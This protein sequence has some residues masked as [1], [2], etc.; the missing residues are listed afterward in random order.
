MSLPRLVSSTSP[1]SVVDVE[2]PNLA[3]SRCGTAGNPSTV[4][5]KCAGEDWAAST[6]YPK[7]MTGY[8]GHQRNLEP[9][10][11]P[12]RVISSPLVG[13]TGNYRGKNIGKLGRCETHR[14]RLSAWERGTVA[15]I[16]GV[17]AAEDDWE[18]SHYTNSCGNFS[19][20]RYHETSHNRVKSALTLPGSPSGFIVTNAC[21]MGES[22]ASFGALHPEGRTVPEADRILLQI[23]VALESRFRTATVARSALKSAFFAVDTSRMGVL[24]A[25]VFFDI[26]R[27]QSGVALSAGQRTLLTEALSR[28]G[29]HGC[30]DPEFQQEQLGPDYVL[31]SAR[32]EQDD[33]GGFGGPHRGGEGDGGSGCV[34]YGRFLNI[35]VPRRGAKGSKNSRVPP[36]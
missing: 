27:R 35:I 28:A 32:L 33:E 4:D 20:K 14:A 6:Y 26:L 23:Q 5:N 24:A 29:R 1:T 17:P 2:T 7:Y 15:G 13:Y 11:D 16:L 36:G 25:E 12:P 10:A 31:G 18:F 21:S 8:G 19:D 22:G 30:G 34:V 3:H 9:E